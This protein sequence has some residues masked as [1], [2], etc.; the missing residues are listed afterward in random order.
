MVGTFFSALGLF[1]LAR[2]GGIPVPSTRIH[3][4]LWFAV[5]VVQVVEYILVLLSAIMTILAYFHVRYFHGACMYRA[6]GESLYVADVAFFATM[7]ALPVIN[8]T[9]LI[10]FIYAY[11]MSTCLKVWRATSSISNVPSSKRKRTKDREYERLS[12]EPSPRGSTEETF[13]RELVRTDQPWP[14]ALWHVRIA[15]LGLALSSVISLLLGG[16]L[17]SICFYPDAVLW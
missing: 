2:F 1:T 15:F 4:V 6:S 12:E 17:I 10:L 3:T 11:I 16:L 8:Q 7:F 5:F 14:I 13:K 9:L